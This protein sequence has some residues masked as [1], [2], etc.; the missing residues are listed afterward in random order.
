MKLSKAQRWHEMASRV[1]PTLTGTDLV[2]I[3][4]GMLQILYYEKMVGSSSSNFSDLV[5]N[6]ERIESGLKTG[7]IVDGN[8]QHSAVRRP[9]SRYVKKEKGR[10]MH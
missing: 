5:T 4:M 6:G 9:S 10:Q 3:F 8:S 7:K 2:D 1:R